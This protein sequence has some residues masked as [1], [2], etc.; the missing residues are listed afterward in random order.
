MVM[1][2]PLMV[3]V[4]GIAMAGCGGNPLVD[5]TRELRLMEETRVAIE[6]LKGRMDLAYP[7]SA[8][9]WDETIRVIDFHVDDPTS[10]YRATVEEVVAA[11]DLDGGEWLLAFSTD[12][13]LVDGEWVPREP[14]STL[15][16]AKFDAVTG[17]EVQ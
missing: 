14:D 10:D 2:R 4:M 5:D 8:Q 13:R 6:N 16:L 17:R 15:L 11:L 1:K 12:E 3:A 9:V 7:A